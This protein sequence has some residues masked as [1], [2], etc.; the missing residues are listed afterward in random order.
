MLPI[1]LGFKTE[2]NKSNANVRDLETYLRLRNS[3]AIT[4]T[5]PRTEVEVV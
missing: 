5:V 4:V 2:I 3:A 1:N